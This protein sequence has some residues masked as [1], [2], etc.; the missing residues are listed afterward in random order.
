MMF[1]YKG[2]CWWCRGVADSR[3]HKYKKSD[4]VREFGAGPWPGEKALVRVSDAGE[5]PQR[6]SGPNSDKL[7]FGKSL[8]ARCNNERSQPFDYAYERLSSYI[9]KNEDKIIQRGCFKQSTAWHSSWRT[10]RVNATKYFVKHIACRIVEE[11]LA[12]PASLKDYLDSSID[13]PLGLHLQLGIRLDYAIMERHMESQHQIP[14]G[15]VWLGPMQF[16]GQNEITAVESHVGFGAVRA[17]YFVDFRG[18]EFRTNLYKNRVRVPL[19]YNIDPS[20]VVGMCGLC[21]PETNES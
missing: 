4:I 18:S 7:K 16:Y 2:R 1:D 12:A 14:P 15:A 20:S 9:S 3:E 17:S 19:E 10:E 8:C 6:V 21:F 5:Y 11:G 13:M